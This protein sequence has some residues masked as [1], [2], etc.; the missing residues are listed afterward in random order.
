MSRKK[1]TNERVKALE[2]MALRRSS[3]ASRHIPLTHKGTRS[4]KE[5]DI[6]RDQKEN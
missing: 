1:I 5:R 4:Q 2:R 3:A 6:I